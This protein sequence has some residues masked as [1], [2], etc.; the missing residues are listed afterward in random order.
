MKKVT[1][2]CGAGILSGKEAMA[3]ELGEGLQEQGCEV[4]VITSH[5]GDGRFR[6]RL[7]E[8]DLPVTC[9]RL[10][11]IS[12]TLS[13]DCLRMTAD[14]FVRLPGLWLDYCR[15]MRHHTP[16]HVIHTNWHHLLVLWPLLRPQRDSFWLHDVIP[17]KPQYRRVFR[18]LAG[19]LRRFVPVS[20]A[21]KASLLRIGIPED[22]IHVIHNGLRISAPAAGDR[23]GSGVRVGIVGQVGPWKG[24]Q[25]LIEAFGSLTAKQPL[26]E[27][28]IYGPDNGGFAQ[29]IRQ[30]AA[31]LRL[32]SRLFWHGFVTD[33]SAIYG[34]LDVCVIPSRATEA[35]PTV[36]IEAAFFGLPVVA[37][38]RGGLPEI[39][40]DGVTGYLVEAERPQELAQRLGELL[41]IADLRE[42]MGAAAR[43]RAQEHF[44]RER[45]VADFLR[46]LSAGEKDLKPQTKTTCAA[47]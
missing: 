45:F 47:V 28:H 26:A 23:K 39:V 11:F 30:R 4:T 18:R 31:E 32:A 16:D 27:L 22:K 15:F 2:I 5:W 6:R 8:L 20:G 9:M 44:S 37:T 40:E 43:K 19:R 10:G 1:I 46:V 38:R 13:P 12:A 14:Q 25:D 24:H 7:A 42:K 29:T 41:R 36:A 17:D 33:R 34:N 21:V 3:L 35:L